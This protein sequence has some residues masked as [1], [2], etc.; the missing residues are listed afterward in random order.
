MRYA[1]Y[2]GVTVLSLY[3]A[4]QTLIHAFFCSESARRLGFTDVTVIKNLL[5][6]GHVATLLLAALPFSIAAACAKPKFAIW[7]LYGAA[8]LIA[9]IFGTLSRGAYI[10]LALLAVMALIILTR[11]PV[12]PT[13]TLVRAW[14]LV[15]VVASI[16][17]CVARLPVAV[18]DTAA[19][20]HSESS[21]RSVE[22]RVLQWRRSA[23]L[24]RAHPITGV[25]SSNFAI[26]YAP[27]AG[28]DA[29]IPLTG[30]SFG[31][32]QAITVERGIIG[33]IAF[34]AFWAMLLGV[35]LRVARFS[36]DHEARRA[37]ALMA[38]GFCA[39]ICRDLTYTSVFDTPVSS[40]VAIMAA[41]NSSLL[42]T[43]SRQPMRRARQ[44][45]KLRE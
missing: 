42:S 27:L 5:P 11:L 30:L 3:L 32:F 36:D 33:L 7:H 10:A 38:I 44:I 13:R 45:E 16:V 34:G 39:L 24:V 19:M 23:A 9:A 18:T 20:G 12:C 41:H 2:T 37:A 26:A 1:L 28:L 25:G 29:D 4:F 43:M 21:W 17:I 40:L 6:G 8:L 15:V 14:T 35:S 22:G 31:V